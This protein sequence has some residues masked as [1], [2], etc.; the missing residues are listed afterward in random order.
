MH[1]T[2]S[3]EG[4]G[5]KDKALAEDLFRRILA[6]RRAEYVNEDVEEWVKKYIPHSHW[7]Y[8]WSRLERASERR[9]CKRNREYDDAELLQ[10][11]NVVTDRMTEQFTKAHFSGATSEELRYLQT[12]ILREADDCDVEYSLE[13]LLSLGVAGI[14][15]RRV[16]KTRNAD[17]KKA[18]RWGWQIVYS[19]MQIAVVFGIYSALQ[20]PFEI[21][22][23]SLLIEVYCT[24]VLSESRSTLRFVG[25]VIKADAIFSDIRQSLGKP[26]TRAAQEKADKVYK[27]LQS[28]QGQV[29]AYQSTFVIMSLIALWH[30]IRVIVGL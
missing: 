30:L 15:K 14:R 12:E 4:P 21:I 17:V 8:N 11:D 22:V 13:T 20:R 16:K 6:L 5:D 3:Q 29:V 27:D 26:V 2:I 7:I 23:V 24:V 18:F 1:D 9:A 19:L 25:N 28:G 10:L